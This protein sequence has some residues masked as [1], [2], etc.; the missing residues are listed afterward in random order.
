MSC[1]EAFSIYKIALKTA[2]DSYRRNDD[3]MQLVVLSY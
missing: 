3:A 2:T 1:R